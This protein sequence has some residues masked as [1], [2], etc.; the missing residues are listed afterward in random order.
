MGCELPE[1]A[2]F[3]HALEYRRGVVA[4]WGDTAVASTGVVAVRSNGLGR[5]SGDTLVVRLSDDDVRREKKLS[6]ELVALLLVSW[7]MGRLRLR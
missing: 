2:I 5:G 7:S 3:F 1:G 4:C 6:L